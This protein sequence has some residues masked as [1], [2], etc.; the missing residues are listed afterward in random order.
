M[1]ERA[2]RDAAPLMDAG[3]TFPASAPCVQSAMPERILR[4]EADNP[5]TLVR[6]LQEEW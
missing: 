1:A 4:A 6:S 5:L 3:P 2:K